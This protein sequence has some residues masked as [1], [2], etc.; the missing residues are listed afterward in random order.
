MV[1]YGLGDLL[2]G[3]SILSLEWIY[4]SGVLLFALLGLGFWIWRCLFDLLGSDVFQSLTNDC[5]HGEDLDALLSILLLELL[6]DGF[7]S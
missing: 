6:G 4:R 5:I 2:V 1:L 7:L 3:L